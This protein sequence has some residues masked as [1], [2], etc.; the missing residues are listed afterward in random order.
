[1]LPLLANIFSVMLAST[2]FMSNTYSQSSPESEFVGMYTQSDVDSQSQLFLLDDNTFCFT[3]MGGTLDL[4]KTGR[5]LENKAEGTINLQ[6]TRPD[7]S[8]Y[9]AL[10]KNLDRL[11][12]PVVG[13]N[14]DGYLLSNAISPVFAVTSNDTQPTTFRP[15]FPDENFS[16]ASTYALPLMSAEKAKYF[17]I[18]DLELDAYDRPKR[19]RVVQYKFG[20]F[21]TVRIG[22]NEIQSDPAM[23]MNA[24]LVNNV[25]QLDGNTF[26]SK[27]TLTLNMIAEVREHCINPILYPEKVTTSQNKGYEQLPEDGKLLLPTR[28]F[29]LD[30]TAVNGKPF[31]EIKGQSTTTAT[32]SLDDLVESEKIQLQT[33]FNS[34]LGDIKTLDQFLKLAKSVTEKRQRIKRHVPLLVKYF[35][36]L[37]VAVTAT[38]NFTVSEEIFLNYMENIYPVTAGVTNDEMLYGISVVAS[39]GLIITTPLKNAEISKYVFDKL[40]GDKYD[41]TTHKNGTLIYN[42]ACFYAINNNKTAMLGAIKQARKRGKP[43]G[44]FMGDTDF[45]N[46]W[47]DTDF[48]NAVN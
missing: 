16:W 37:L 35:A 3:F 6:E 39:Q 41:I 30:V 4:V 8:V 10:A 7:T 18:G 24:Q 34:A 26:G 2:V 15:L 1:M 19:L 11:G 40:L 13:I 29:Y 21:D 47:S 31:F 48:L 28:Q 27:K 20:N 44:Q 46:Y 42:L 22:F 14:F 38:G 45:K 9:P 23:N 25:L 17:F 43:S 36:E 33:A 5:W 12:T 32:D